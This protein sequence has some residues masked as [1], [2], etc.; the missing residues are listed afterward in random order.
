MNIKYMKV[1]LFEISYKK[2]WTLSPYYIFFLCNC[3]P[4]YLRTCLFI[5]LPACTY[6]DQNYKRNTF[7]FVLV[8][9]PA[10]SMPIAGS[11][12]TSLALWCVIK[13]HILE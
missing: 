13:L 4:V 12:K 2:K 8:D 5:F 1:S 7:V 9:I 3:L 11:L 10:V 6:I